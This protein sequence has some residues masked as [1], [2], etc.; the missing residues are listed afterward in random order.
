VRAGAIDVGTNSVRLIVC[1]QQP[2]GMRTL[3]RRLTIT[4]LGQGVDE[5]RAF[6]PEALK[7]TLE[8]IAEYAAI[9]G[10]YEV[11]DIR[12]SATSAARDARDRDVFFDAV[13]KLTG[14]PAELLS[15]ADEARLTFTG[16][17]SDLAGEDPVLVVD[18][19]GGSTEL[20]VGRK[21]PENLVSLDIGSVRLFEKHLASD[22]PSTSELEAL[23][24]EAGD[25]FRSARDRLSVS[26]RSRLVGVAGTVTQLAALKIGLPTYDPEVTHHSVLSHGDIRML[27]RRLASLPYEKRARIK[28]LVPGRADVIVSGAE[29]LLSVMEVFDFAEVLVSEKDLLD[30][31]AIEMLATD[32]GT[33]PR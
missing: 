31:L 32:A 29:I 19:G 10:E 12:V 18:I 2:G 25:A 30:G 17:V 11:S 3:D 28:G 6:D 23:R 4:R 8:T 5:R 27:A 13:R 9:C 21:K 24:T 33:V 26:P 15:G 14:K 7:R 16:A 20:V 22:P 1:E